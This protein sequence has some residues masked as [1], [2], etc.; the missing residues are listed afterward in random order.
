MGAA[1]RTRLAYLD[2]FGPKT[3]RSPLW[4]GTRKSFTKGKID[5]YETIGKAFTGSFKDLVLNRDLA[6]CLLCSE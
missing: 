2:N 1:E 5:N 6:G 4:E 3:S